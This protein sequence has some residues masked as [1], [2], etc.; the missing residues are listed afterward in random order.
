MPR[1]VH[2]PWSREEDAYIWKHRSEPAEELGSALGRGA[3][4]VAGRLKR[5]ADPSTDGYRRL[6]GPDPSDDDDAEG[7]SAVR[8]R[9][10]HECIQRII[11]DN[12]L[13]PKEFT[14]GYRDRFAAAPLLAPFDAPN[15]SIEGRERLFVLA[16]PEHRIEFLLYRKRLVWHKE[17]RLDYIFGSGARGGGVRIADIMAGYADWEADRA[18]RVRRA[19]RRAIGLVGERGLAALL[20]LLSR[21]RD[22]ES[23]VDDFVEAALSERYFAARGGVEAAAGASEDTLRKDSRAEEVAPSAQPPSAQ[24]PFA[25]EPPA[26]LELL[27]V[28]PEERVTLSEELLERVSARLGYPYPGCTVTV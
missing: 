10:A 3:K 17:L 4:G 15:Q 1:N 28:L 13:D 26:V 2:T 21:V 25:P 8:L 16:L 11:W 7:S 14:L 27:G 12:S 5:L 19:R 23:T 20:Q 6:F 18:L 24:P 9:P 22:G